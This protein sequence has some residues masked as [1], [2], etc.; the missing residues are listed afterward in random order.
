MSGTYADSYCRANVIVNSENEV[1][2]KFKFLDK[3]KPNTQ[4]TFRITRNYNDV[5]KLTPI[6]KDVKGKAS[7][8]FTKD[9]KYVL[10]VNLYA[11]NGD[12]DFKGSKHED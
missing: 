4:Y 7:I 11:E 5:V 3:Y 6:S 2:M 12:I 1:I 10:R 8:V 9:K